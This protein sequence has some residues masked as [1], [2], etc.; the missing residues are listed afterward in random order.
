MN[1]GARSDIDRWQ[2]FLLPWNGHAIIPGP[3]GTRAPNL[4]LF[5]DASGSIGYGIVYAGHWIADP[6]PPQ[7]IN[8]MEKALPIA[9]ASLLRV[10]H[11]SGKKLLF[12]CD[13]QAVVDIWASGSSWD[14]LTMHLVR[15]ILFSAATN[16]FI[17]LSLTLSAL[18]MLQ[19]YR[20]SSRPGPNPCPP[21]SIN[22]L[23]FGD[24]LA[25]VSPE[26]GKVSQPLRP[27]YASLPP[28]WLTKA[29]TR[30]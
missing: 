1:C 20:T 13:N 10:D 30:P 7:S 3:H 9:L 25:S 2:R 4:E 29:A 22:P 21:V 19:P 12:H 18:I 26:D 5:T 6:W 8:P 27:H 24:T 14:T 28:S 15:S 23:A 16:H 17:V 11:W